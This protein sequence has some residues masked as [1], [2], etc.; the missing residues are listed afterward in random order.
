MLVEQLMDGGFLW[1]E[2]QRGHV[3]V[4]SVAAEEL[5]DGRVDVFT[6]WHLQTHKEN[7]HKM[8]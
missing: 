1:V 6:V 3:V 2:K 4:G 8:T 5:T 7:T